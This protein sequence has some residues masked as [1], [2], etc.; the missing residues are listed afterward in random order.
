MLPPTRAWLVCLCAFLSLSP[1]NVLP[2]L[3]V[4][5]FLLEVQDQNVVGCWCLL[6]L[7]LCLAQGPARENLLLLQGDAMCCKCGLRVL[8]LCW[9]CL[10]AASPRSVLHGALAFVFL[11]PCFR[12]SQP[13]LDFEFCRGKRSGE[14]R[15]AKH[16]NKRPSQICYI[17]IN[18]YMYMSMNAT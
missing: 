17:G 4:C 12:L 14:R 3:L 6:F 11:G 9:L 1:R 2:G 15:E 16:V 10:G 7:R 18:V 13:R 5:L 8:I